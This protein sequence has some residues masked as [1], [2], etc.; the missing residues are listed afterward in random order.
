MAE[1]TTTSSRVVYR[2]RWMEVREDQIL[3]ADGSPGLY[4]VVH[5][6]DFALIIP[7]DET[8]FHLVQQYRYPANGRF[9]EFPQ[10]TWE[11]SPDIDPRELARRELAE[12]TGLRAATLRPL[13][14]LYEAYGFA[15]HRGHVFLATDLTPGPANPDPEEGPLT[16]HHVPFDAF[17]R[18]VRDGKIADAI[19]LAAYNLLALDQGLVISK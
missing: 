17:P 9:W 5:K 3:H 12:E 1:I 18:L 10:G 15:T 4:G 13:G 7:M 6:P 16:S 8:G 11:D 14:V 19:S 2:N